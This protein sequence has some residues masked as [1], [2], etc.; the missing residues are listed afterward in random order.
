MQK[1]GAPSGANVQLLATDQSNLEHDIIQSGWGDAQGSKI[2]GKD[3][4][5]VLQTKAI[6]SEEGNYKITLKLIDRDN[7]D[8]VIAE[9]EFDFSVLAE[10]TQTPNPTPTPNPNPIEKPTDTPTEETPNNN[11][12]AEDKINETPKIL[13]KTGTNLYVP[14]AVILIALI[15]AYIF[16]NIKK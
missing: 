4:S 11:Q 12:G 3:V 5:Q 9:K 1:L 10:Q 14:I 2:G 6:F 13:P 7:S 16:F 15:S 8:T